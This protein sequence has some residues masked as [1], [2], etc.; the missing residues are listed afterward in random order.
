MG[1][2]ALVYMNYSA[3][4]YTQVSM[5]IASIFTYLTLNG[6]GVYVIDTHH[7]SVDQ[8]IETC[9]SLDVDFV[10]FST[11]E[12]HVDVAYSIAE[13]V[14]NC[15]KKPQVIFGGPYPSLHPKYVLSN[16]FVDYVCVGDGEHPLDELLDGKNPRDIQGI[17]Y[18]KGN[19]V[20]LNGKSKHFDLDTFEVTDYSCFPRD[21]IVSAR[22]LGQDVLDISFTWSSRGCAYACAYCSNASLNKQLRY[23]IKFRNPENVIGEIISLQEG[24]GCDGIFLADENFLFSKPHY[25]AFASQYLCKDI[26]IPFGFLSRPEHINVDDIDDLKLLAD[27]GWKWVST[28]IEMGNEKKRTQFLNR[29]NSNEEIITAFNLCKELDISTIAFLITGLYFE[30]ID[31]LIITEQLLRTCKPDAIEASFIYL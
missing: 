31:D 20:V 28:G 5:G 29:R 1:S 12:L 14:S 25:S 10:G 24:Y 3:F 21:T 18:K 17:C 16:K 11:T 23:D 22:R 2:I 26:G 7:S 27:A 13:E 4:K 6:H 19:A 30:D 15:H 8:I 9:I